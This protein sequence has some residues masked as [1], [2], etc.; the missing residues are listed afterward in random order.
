[1][2]AFAIRQNELAYF[3]P[4]KPMLFIHS[5]QRA[6]SDPEKLSGLTAE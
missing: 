1:M 2:A 6:V 5:P 4:R 3:P